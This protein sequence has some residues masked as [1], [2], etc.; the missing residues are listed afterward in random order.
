MLEV[1]RAQTGTFGPLDV[2]RTDLAAEVLAL[3]AAIERRDHADAQREGITVAELHARRERDHRADVDR[4]TRESRL[5]NLGR[6]ACRMHPDDVERVISTDPEA[7]ADSK[8][9]RVLERFARS[10]RAFV[11]LSGPRGI[12]KTVAAAAL[13]A[14]LGGLV[15]RPDEVVTAFRNEH[16]AAR[17]LRE[18][19][20]DTSLVVLDDLGVELAADASVRAFHALV[21]QRQGGQRRTVVTTN[22]TRLELRAAYDVRTLERI[23]HGGAF[24]ELVGENRRRTA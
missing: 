18:Q 24:V 10:G 4:A 16:E 14:R 5:E 13:K 1:K 9:W 7:L 19:L 17:A 8:A 22:L 11:V 23:T 2:Q 20:I 3:R 15:V 12:G 21:D 6:D